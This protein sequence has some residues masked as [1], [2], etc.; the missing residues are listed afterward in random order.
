MNN[1]TGIK[2]HDWALWAANSPWSDIIWE[3]SEVIWAEPLIHP[4][5]KIARRVSKAAFVAVFHDIFET[6]D[7]YEIADF[8]EY[9]Y[10]KI[11]L[12]W[13]IIMMD[14]KKQYGKVLN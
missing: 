2:Q 6:K 5:T 9:P 11:S 13:T 12:P 14:V 8:W 1:I 3:N 10:S 4:D 7:P